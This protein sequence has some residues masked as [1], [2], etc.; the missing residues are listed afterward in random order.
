[1]RAEFDL[2]SAAEIIVKLSDLL[3]VDIKEVWEK[4]APS[5]IKQ[6]FSYEEIEKEIIANHDM[7]IQSPIPWE[8]GDA[9]TL[10]S[11]IVDKY[12]N[13]IANFDRRADIGYTL[14][15]VNGYE[16]L[17]NL[18]LKVKETSVNCGGALSAII[19][20]LIDESLREEM[21]K[22][23]DYEDSES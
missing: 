7:S 3:D 13:D 20:K 12:G 17:M 22:M 5:A 16:K 6:N 9:E 4:D 10:S 21:D 15:C 2:V 1:M 11:D 18:I 19:V 14:K 23:A 8:R